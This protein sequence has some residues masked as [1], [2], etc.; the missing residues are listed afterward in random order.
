MKD[1]RQLGLPGLEKPPA[2]RLSALTRVRIDHALIA[3]ALRQGEGATTRP[4]APRRH[5]PGPRGQLYWRRD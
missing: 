2:P 1:G 3:R 4:T 5:T